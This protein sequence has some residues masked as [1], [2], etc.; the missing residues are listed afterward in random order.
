MRVWKVIGLAGV[1]GVAA[2]GVAVAR[3]QRK[4]NSYTPDEIRSKLRERVD[5]STG[6]LPDS[7]SSS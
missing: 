1:A 6:T 4:R 3:E 5:G 2:G 7:P